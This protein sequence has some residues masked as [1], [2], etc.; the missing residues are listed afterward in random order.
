MQI[1]TVS[2]SL[3]VAGIVAISSLVTSMFTAWIVHRSAERRSLRELA[4]SAALK[5]WEE[6]LRD[7]EQK[8]KEGRL[9]LIP[10]MDLYI[11]HMVLLTEVI[12]R[13]SGNKRKLVSEISRVREIVD[14]VKNS[15]PVIK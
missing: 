1:D 4:M 3:L 10:P 9:V 12:V 7:C 8:K 11:L 15:M 14:S 13:H 2:G 6:M 5:N